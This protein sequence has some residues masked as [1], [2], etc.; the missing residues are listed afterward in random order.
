MR[1]KRGRGEVKRKLTV[2]P[3]IRLFWPCLRG[4]PIG[5]SA[6]RLIDKLNAHGPVIFFFLLTITTTTTTRSVS[7]LYSGLLCCP[8]LFS[9][10]TIPSLPM[11]LDSLVLDVL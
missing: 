7:L 3:E 6:V 1:L 10:D 8:A 9:Q 4:R 11:R 2:K 5:T